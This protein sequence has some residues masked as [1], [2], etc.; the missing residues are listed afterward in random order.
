MK[1]TSIALAVLISFVLAG[2]EDTTPTTDATIEGLWKVLSSTSWI[3][4]VRRPTVAQDQPMTFEFA[5]EFEGGRITWWIPP[6]TRMAGAH[7]PPVGPAGLTINGTY[8]PIAEAGVI[9]VKFP[10]M[11]R[12]TAPWVYEM[13]GPDR[14]SIRV[15]MYGSEQEVYDP[16]GQPSTSTSPAL[17]SLMIL[18]RMSKSN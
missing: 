17:V 3:D 2:C 12:N 13:Q 6:G 15:V 9:L 5:A 14:M 7:S 11:D 10:T 8:S 16:M 1:R 4:G 18:E